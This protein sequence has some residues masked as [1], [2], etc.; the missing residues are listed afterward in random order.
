MYSEQPGCIP[1][2]LVICRVDDFSTP[3]DLRLRDDEVVHRISEARKN[4]FSSF[5][6]LPFFLP[7]FF[8]TIFWQL[9]T[10]WWN[11]R[12]SIILRTLLL[13]KL[14]AASCQLRITAHTVLYLP[15]ADGPYDS[16]T[17]HLHFMPPPKSTRGSQ[18]GGSA[19]HYG[20]YALKLCHGWLADWWYFFPFM[21]SLYHVYCCF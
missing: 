10:V 17:Q 4:W 8:I 15:V 2:V 19:V 3:Q 7:F 20:I 5:P 13:H 16:R 21:E 11:R 1:C 9:A 6:L 12:H 18:P 14:P